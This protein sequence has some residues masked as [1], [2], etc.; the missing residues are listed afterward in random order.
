[1][2]RPTID[3]TG[4]KILAVDDVPENLDVLVHTL[5]ETGYEVLIAT[6]GEQ[7][8]ELKAQL[9]AMQ[10]QLEAMTRPPVK[11]ATKR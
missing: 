11:S 8:L 9:E 5:E 7:A 1:M 3:L 10:A 2:T 4:T 6:S